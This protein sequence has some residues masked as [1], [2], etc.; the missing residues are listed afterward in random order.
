MT[1]N[2]N[3]NG[4]AAGAVEALVVVRVEEAIDPAL[5]G[6]QGAAYESPPQS[7]E[8]AMALVRLLLGGPWG[9]ELRGEVF[10]RARAYVADVFGEQDQT[11][12]GTVRRRPGERRSKG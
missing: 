8:Q 12:D 11:N 1:T 4:R 10:N 6:R 7:R 9:H 3:G 2:G 5:A